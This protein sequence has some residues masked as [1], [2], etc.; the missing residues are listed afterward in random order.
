MGGMFGGGSPPRNGADQMP[1]TP[2][3]QQQVAKADVSCFPLLCSA[4]DTSSFSN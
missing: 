3:W 2:L 1:M 4:N